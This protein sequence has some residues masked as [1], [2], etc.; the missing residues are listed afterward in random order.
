[1]ATPWKNGYWYSTSMSSMLALIEGN[2]F[3]WKQMFALDY[4]DAK[5]MMQCKLRF[6]ENEKEFGPAHSDVVNET[7]KAFYNMEMDMDGMKFHM[8]LSDDGKK[9]CFIGM[10][11]TMDIFNWCDEELLSK[12][13]ENRDPCDAP[14]SI[15]KPRPNEP[16]K[17]IWLSGK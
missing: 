3:L 12:L 7:G 5:P 11:G 17:I 4:P 16:G 1:M 15:Y 10:T 8:V 14:P 9:L 6:A 2:N 13:R